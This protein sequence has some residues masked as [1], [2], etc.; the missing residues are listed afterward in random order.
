MPGDRLVNDTGVSQETKGSVN[1]QRP[2]VAD[3]DGRKKTLLGKSFVGL[4]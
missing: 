4:L 3:T 1:D 2:Q